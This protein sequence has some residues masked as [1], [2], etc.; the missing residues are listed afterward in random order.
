LIKKCDRESA[1]RRTH[2]L[3]TDWRKPIL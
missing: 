1:H 3:K 2:T